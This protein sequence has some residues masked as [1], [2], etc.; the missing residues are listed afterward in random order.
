MYSWLVIVLLLASA[1]NS[2]GG[3]SAMGGGLGR[4][5]VR[6]CQLFC[7]KRNRLYLSV[8]PYTVGTVYKIPVGLYIYT[9]PLRCTSAHHKL[10]MYTT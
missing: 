7:D 3:Q 4:G 2:S 10:H 6:V 1:A 5:G 8:I 9:F